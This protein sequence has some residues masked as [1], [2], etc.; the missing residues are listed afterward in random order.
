MSMDY[1]KLRPI[2][3]FPVEAEGRQLLCLRDPLQYVTESVFVPRESL[4]IL[5]YFDGQHTILDIQTAYARKTGEILFSDVVKQIIEELDTHLMLDSE[6][7]QEYQQ[8]VEK[9][10]REQAT[11]PASHAGSAYPNDAE[12]LKGQLMDY[13][14]PPDGPGFP[15]ASTESDSSLVGAVAPHIDLRRGGPCF[16]HA[17][18]EIVEKSNADLFIILG[19]KHTGYR[20][21]YTATHKDFE[22]PLG[23]VQTDTDFIDLLQQNYDSELLE[24]EFFHKNEHSI[25]F[26][27]VFLQA[28]LGEMKPFRIVPIICSSFDPLVIAGGDPRDESSVSGFID[29]LKGA[30]AAIDA[31]VCIIASVDLSH[32]GA[33]FGDRFPLN[34]VVRDRI[35]EEDLEML[36]AA[37]NVDTRAFLETIRR[38]KNQRRVDG[39]CP[40]YTLLETLQPTSGKLLRY[41]QGLESETNSV[42]TFASM[43]FYQD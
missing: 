4:P 38:T 25:E 6:K 11:R 35:R 29:S 18:K 5:Q 23:T 41:D 42:V 21:M 40:I 19:V 28:V 10:F 36:R 31:S 34:T 20:G 8:G 9:T 1:P 24:D 14:Q 37:E 33:R 15:D 12:Q 7:F 30:I 39:V 16:A 17:Y 3:V 26:Q 22:T 2:E 27:A 32:V 13:F 43:G